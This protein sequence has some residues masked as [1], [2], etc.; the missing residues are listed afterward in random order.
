MTS[1]KDYLTDREKLMEKIKKIELEDCAVGSFEAVMEPCSPQLNQYVST[2]YPCEN[3][4]TVPHVCMPLDE[5]KALITSEVERVRKEKQK[6]QEWLL[7]YQRQEILKEVEEKVKE[8]RK[9][10]EDEMTGNQEASGYY[11]SGVSR[12]ENGVRKALSDI[13][14]ERK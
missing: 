14:E 3:R 5:F 11:V 1:P 2:D 6:E 8:Q 4:W 7:D 13:K 9:I 12:M 10:I